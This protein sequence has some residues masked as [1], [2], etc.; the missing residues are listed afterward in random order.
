[1][2]TKRR[3]PKLTASLTTTHSGVD[4]SHGI[5][6]GCLNAPCICIHSSHR[7]TISFVR[8]GTF[9]LL[10]LHEFLAFYVDHLTPEVVK[11]KKGKTFLLPYCHIFPCFESVLF[12]TS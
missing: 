8:L 12:L 9:M 6:D 10:H 1:M 5:S 3:T 11:V 4:P 7:S 2:G